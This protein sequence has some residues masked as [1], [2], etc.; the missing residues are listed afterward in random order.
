MLFILKKNSHFKKRR[1]RCLNKW[2]PLYLV[3]KRFIWI[4]KKKFQ[5]KNCIFNNADLNQHQALGTSVS[6]TSIFGS[7]VPDTAPHA[8]TESRQCTPVLCSSQRIPLVA[9]MRSE[10][11]HWVQLRVKRGKKD[12]KDNCASS[13]NVLRK[14]NIEQAFDL[15]FS[16][17][18][19]TESHKQ[20]GHSAR[21]RG[22]LLGGRL[23]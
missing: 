5:I 15:F 23:I 7:A 4:I 1:Q 14:T 9:L 2:K 8:N 22:Q 20:S 3:Q 11:L 21:M 18:V 12:R 17:N 13:Y 16:V 10:N 6:R 19:K